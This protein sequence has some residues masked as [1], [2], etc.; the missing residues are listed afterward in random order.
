MKTK[1]TEA[2]EAHIVLPTILKHLE[3]SALTTQHLDS[4]KSVA[5][6]ALPLFHKQAASW[7]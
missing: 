1:K 5:S 4:P 7:N 3:I 2:M 6:A